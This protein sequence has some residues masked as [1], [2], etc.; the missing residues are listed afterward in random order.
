MIYGYASF[1]QTV[2]GVICRCLMNGFFSPYSGKKFVV[3][4]GIS[5]GYFDSFPELCIYGEK[6][7]K[8][9]GADGP[10]NI[11]CRKEEDGSIVVFEINPR[12]SGSVA[13]RSLMGHNEPD[14]LIQYKL[15]DVIPEINK[16]IPGYVMKDFDEKFISFNDVQKKHNND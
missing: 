16:I 14:I 13:S 4:S 10:I 8:I 11:Q 2:I 15:N 9:V 3:S 12:F 7:A 5:Q 6:I 1:R